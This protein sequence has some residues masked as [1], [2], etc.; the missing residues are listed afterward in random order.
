M[1]FARKMPEFL[2]D[3]FPENIFPIFFVEQGVLARPLSSSPTPVCPV[4]NYS[5]PVVRCPGSEI[6]LAPPLSKGQYVS[7]GLKRI[8]KATTLLLRGK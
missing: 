8:G 1:I 4:R 2:Q 5:A 6:F 3:N 7:A